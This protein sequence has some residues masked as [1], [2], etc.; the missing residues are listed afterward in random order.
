MATLTPIQ[1]PEQPTAFDIGA[2]AE[3]VAADAAGDQ[4]PNAGVTGFW[5][6]NTSGAQRTVTIAGQLNCDHG[7]LHDAPVAV[8]DGFTG[9]IASKLLEN[10]FSPGVT[11]VQ[12]TYDNEAGLRVAAVRL[13]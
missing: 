3:T 1:F 13:A 11:E 9:F 6:E 2:Q 7:F 10:R 4:F 12:V 8:P 5:V